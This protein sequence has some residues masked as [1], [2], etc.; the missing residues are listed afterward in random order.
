MKEFVSSGDKD[1]ATRCLKD[2]DVPHY[3]HELVYE[4][5]MIS[6]EAEDDRVINSMTWLL[7][8]MF[9]EVYIFKIYQ[10][11]TSHNR[12]LPRFSVPT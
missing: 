1:E 7:Q 12:N 4:A 10:T 2:L 6:M 8:Y 3:H 11:L 9:K 5:I